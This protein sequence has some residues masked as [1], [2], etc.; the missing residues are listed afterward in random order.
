MHLMWSAVSEKLFRFSVA[1]TQDE[2]ISS[3]QI[4]VDE[5]NLTGVCGEAHS[6]NVGFRFNRQFFAFNSARR[7]KWCQTV[8]R[9]KVLCQLQMIRPK[10]VV[11]HILTNL[12]H[13]THICAT[14]SA[15]AFCRLVD[16]IF[17]G[18]ISRNV[19]AHECNIYVCSSRKKILSG[20]T[21]VLEIPVL[22]M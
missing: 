16:A 5:E 2:H 19:S 21:R 3:T 6:I 1:Q 22:Y 17:S 18:Y 13:E 14:E 15:G 7:R 9:K 4:P 8:P 12:S 20:E 10:T 11:K